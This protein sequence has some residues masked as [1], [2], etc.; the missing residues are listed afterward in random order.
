MRAANFAAGWTLCRPGDQPRDVRH[1]RRQLLDVLRKRRPVLDVAAA[2]R[3]AGQ[4]NFELFIVDV[5]G[6]VEPVRVT[7][8][9]GFD[10]LPVPTPDGR[11]LSWSS[12]RHGD[13][14][15]QIYLGEWNHEHALESLAQSP[16]RAAAEASP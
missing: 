3:T 9:D 12:T 1:D 6:S 5:A 4:G 15:A 13:P 14:G 7:T 10:G 16:R 2:L 8:T 11:G